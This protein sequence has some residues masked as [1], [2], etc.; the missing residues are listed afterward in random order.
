[1]KPARNPRY[2]AWVRTQSCSVCGSKQAVEAAHTGPH[3]IGQKSSNY[4]TIP[5]CAKHHR[6]GAESYHRLGPRKFSA[7]HGLDIPAIVRRLNTKPAIR[8]ESGIFIAHLDGESYVL[9]TVQA[10]IQSAVR[11]AIRL[12]RENRLGQEVAS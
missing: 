11:R 3:G 7:V 4:A 6:T 10:G 12:C 9:G 5:L 2:L 1:M 8:V